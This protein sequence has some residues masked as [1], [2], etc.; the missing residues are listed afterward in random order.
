MGNFQ[1]GYIIGLLP[2]RHLA[3]RARFPLAV[4]AV[5]AALAMPAAG[6]ASTTSH[7]MTTAGEAHN[8]SGGFACA[9]AS[10]DPIIR[11]AFTSGMGLPTEGYAFC[12]L[13][14]SLVDNIAAGT[15]SAT[16]SA[17]RAFNNGVA[18]LTASAVA[19]YDHIG[20]QSSA[21]FTG[22]T[23]GTAYHSSEGAAI[24]DDALTLAGASGQG[25]V[26]FGFTVD[27]SL[28]A[29]S[30][31]EAQLY[32][33]FSADGSSPQTAFAAVVQGGN[34]RFGAPYTPGFA[35]FSADATTVS[36]SGVA[37]TYAIPFTFGTPLDLQYGLRSYA[38]GAPFTGDAASNFIATA[39]LTSIA[40]TDG[41]G[42]AIDFSATSSSGTLYDAAG[43][44][45]QAVGAVPEPA[46]WTMMLGGFALVGSA[47]RFRRGAGP[48][49]AVRARI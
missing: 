2:R 46:S 16:S 1:L 28:F 44:H 3:S 41:G 32:L 19:D 9:T 12:N 8:A 35:G 13:S 5:L 27:G 31:S 40:A 22:Y 30:N 26:T 36:G 6:Y 49:L 37:Y 15:T 25:Y 18:N 20:A 47:M 24:I 38:Y 33:M 11:N 17:S 14:G 4:Q 29:A 23:S 10:P 21:A 42:N 34:G 39:R 45:V 43:A 7:A 48:A